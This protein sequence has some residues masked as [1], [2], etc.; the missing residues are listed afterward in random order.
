MLIWR[1]TRYQTREFQSLFE[2]A[3]GPGS[4]QL[5]WKNQ[6]FLLAQVQSVFCVKKSSICISDMACLQDTKDVSIIIWAHMSRNNCH[7]NWITIDSLA[8]YHNSLLYV[9]TCHINWITIDSV[10]VNNKWKKLVGDSHM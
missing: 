4:V 6:F 7:I 10:N 1:R 9:E 2:H 8:E 5:R 3:F